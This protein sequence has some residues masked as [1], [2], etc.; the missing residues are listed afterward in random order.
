MKFV[1]IQADGMPD[2]PLVELEGKTP[3]E[4][5]KT[6]F[7]DQLVQSSEMGTINHIPKG[8]KSGSDVGNLSVLGYNP[9]KYFTGRSPIEAESIGINL[10]PDDIC[11]RCNLVKII[12]K[13]GKEFMD[14]HSAGHIDTEISRKIIG[15]LKEKLE[16][17]EFKLYQGVSY[18]HIVVWKGGQ[19]NLETTPPHDILEKNIIQYLPTGPGSVKLRDLM[20]QAR[21]E[22]KKLK[23]LI[24]ELK[25]S[26]CSDI[27]LWGQGKKPTLPHFKSIHK[28]NGSVISAVDL[29]KGIGKLSGL[30][31]L[32]VDG[33][34]GYLDTNYKGKVDAA[35]KSLKKGDFCMIH[36]EA[37]DETG[38]EGN[39]RKK[40]QAITDLDKEVVGPIMEGLKREHNEYKICIVSD[41]P[42]PVDI[43]THSYEYVP[44]MIFDSRLNKNN[45][46]KDT[47]NERSANESNIVHD[48][49]HRLLGSF[50]KS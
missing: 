19:N 43:R 29:I 25:N 32:E 22:I 40:I 35:L 4:A 6:P 21:I 33:A 14:D 5:A 48:D 1:L 39:Y 11:Y 49:G 7:M 30:N 36:I 12:N 3:L 34:T 27:W 8:M 44:Y 38:H 17:A 46:N 41:H 28:I 50:L 2:R 26:D 15:A 20:R 37:P 16:D 18:R 47:F 13:N 45:H 9:E 24:P 31:V 23:N 10:E 42:T